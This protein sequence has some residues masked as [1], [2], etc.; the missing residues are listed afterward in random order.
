MGIGHDP[1]I[2]G[3]DDSGAGAGPPRKQICVV[4]LAV[5]IQVVPDT[6]D[7]NNTRAHTFRKQ[8]HRC[9]ESLKRVGPIVHNCAVGLARGCL[10]VGLR[11]SH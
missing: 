8:L 1:T 10:L 2:R 7:L 4:M 11:F 9:A 3:N 6:K 5:G